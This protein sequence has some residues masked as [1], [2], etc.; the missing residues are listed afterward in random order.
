MSNNPRLQAAL[1]LAQK[2]RYL[3]PC[4]KDKRP[5]IKDWPNNATLD[6]AILKAWFERQ[7]YNLAVVTGHKSNF[8]CLDVDGVAGKDSLLQLEKQYSTIAP[9]TV[10][11]ASTPSNGLHYYFKMPIDLDLRN[12][13]GKLGK[14]LDIRANGD[15]VVVPPSKVVNKDGIEARYEWL[16][17]TITLAKGQLP[18]TPEFKQQMEALNLVK[19]AVAEKTAELDNLKS[20]IAECD[21]TRKN[22]EK[23]VNIANAAEAA[24]THEAKLTKPGITNARKIYDEAQKIISV[25]KKIMAVQLLTMNENKELKQENSHLLVE[26][27]KVRYAMENQAENHKLEVRELNA[28]LQAAIGMR[29]YYQQSN[30][31]LNSELKAQNEFIKQPHIR[32]QYIAYQA[33]KQPKPEKQT[34]E[35]VAPKLQAHTPRKRTSGF[36]R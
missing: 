18:D 8:F 32:L 26:C 2:G 27:Q 30:A 13:A 34:V 28:D 10:C 33:A 9:D 15:Y 24:K 14:G 12:S 6:T 31:K 36:E 17:P 29:D 19:N 20:V 23:Y 11:M 35:V 1:L 3:F 7:P 21:Q 25:Q 16:T 4:D 22:L 5:I